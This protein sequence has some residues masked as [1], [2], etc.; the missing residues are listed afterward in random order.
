M[1]DINLE[2]LSK[3]ANELFSLVDDTNKALNMPVSHLRQDYERGFS[4]AAPRVAVQLQK[5]ISK[6]RIEEAVIGG[7]VLG[8]GYLGAAVIDA[9]RNGWAKKNACEKL[10]AY[11][12]ELV[13]KQNM[14]IDAQ[15][16]QFDKMLKANRELNAGA[17][18][19]KRK[20]D[21]LS[22]IINRLKKLQKQ[23]ES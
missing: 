22:A 7:A 19:Y 3:Q 18:T 11:Y 23:V 10:A 15:K 13:S 6:G 2:E 1:S 20:Y 14:L 21:E 9:A 17:E 16:E 8:L 12:Q 5:T 4:R